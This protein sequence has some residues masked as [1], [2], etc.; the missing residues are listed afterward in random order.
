MKSGKEQSAANGSEP[1][2]L[3]LLLYPHDQTEGDGRGRVIGHAFFSLELG[4]GPADD[5]ATS[6]EAAPT[7]RPGQQRPDVASCGSSQR[8]WQRKAAE[9]GNDEALH[10]YCPRCGAP[11]MDEDGN[12]ERCSQALGPY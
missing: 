2:Q 10:A 4:G 7:R 6:D 3:R 9:R 8:G 5:Q 11:A 12:C 1:L